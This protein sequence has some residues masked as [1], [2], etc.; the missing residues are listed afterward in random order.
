MGDIL[1]DSMQPQPLSKVIKIEAQSLMPTKWNKTIFKKT[2]KIK[3]Q[4]RPLK[5]LNR[6]AKIYEHLI[7]DRGPVK[8][9]Q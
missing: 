7:V 6:P 5:I 8:I 4:K 2:K 9:A 3:K 1:I